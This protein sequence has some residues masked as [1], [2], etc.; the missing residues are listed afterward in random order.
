MHTPSPPPSANVADEKVAIKN[1]PDINEFSMQQNKFWLTAE[2]AWKEKTSY[3]K[4]KGQHCAIYKKKKKK[5]K[6][7]RT[8]Q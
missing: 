8:K 2:G 4:R 7:R 3:W 1:I 5:R 6:K